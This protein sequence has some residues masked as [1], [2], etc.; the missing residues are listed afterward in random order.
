MAGA[1]GLIGFLLITKVLSPLVLFYINRRN[2]TGS[3]IEKKIKHIEN[4][5]LIDI[6]R[7]L[8]DLEKNDIRI[9]QEMYRLG[10]DVSWLKGRFN[11]KP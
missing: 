9:E 2:G 3:N 1:V 10:N 4:N 5:C 7:R 6:N 8:D 11:N